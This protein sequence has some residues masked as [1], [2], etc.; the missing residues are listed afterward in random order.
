MVFKFI[1]K[2]TE[3]NTLYYPG[4]LTKILKLDENYKKI[5]QKLE[6]Q[7]ITLEDTEFCCGSPIIN[8]G[9]QEDF[10]KISG[11][12]MDLFKKHKVSKIITSCPS[13]YNTFKKYYNIEV[14]HITQTILNNIDKL[15]LKNFNEKITYHDPCYLGRYQNIYNEPR[16]ILKALNFEVIEMENNKENSLCCG[17]GSGLQPNLPSIANKA[18]EVRLK[19]VKTSKLITTCPLCYQHF[20]NNSNIKVLELSEVLI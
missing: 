4:C 5:L 19:Q 18:A 15:E 8:V 9:Y 3:K 11:N 2:L 10:Q 7:F 6:I 16:E 13:C 20:K 14:E 12:N 1:K 17:A